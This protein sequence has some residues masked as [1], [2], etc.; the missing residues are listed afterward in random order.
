MNILSSV[1]GAIGTTPL[2]ELSRMTRG[3]DGRLLVVL[4]IAKLLAL[5]EVS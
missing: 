2:V 1:V 3:L 4:D 5:G